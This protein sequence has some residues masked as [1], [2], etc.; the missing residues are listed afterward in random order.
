MISVIQIRLKIYLL[1]DIPADKVQAETAAFIDKGLVQS[2]QFAELHSKNRYKG[3]CFDS[4]YP[5]EADKIY[6]HD[7]IYTLTIRTIDTDLAR[8]FERQ[9]VNGYTNTMKALTSEI[10]IIPF[11]YIDILWPLVPVILKCENGYWKDTLS[12]EQYEE[13]LKINLLKKWNQFCGEKLAE[14]FEM[15][16]GIEFLNRSPLAVAYKGIRLLG[17]KPRLHIAEN[18]SAQKLAQLAIGTGV[19]EMNSR[20]CGFC[21]YRWL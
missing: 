20:G 13:R 18:E 3:Y 7:K 10:K 19:G 8:F 16:I 2:T 6:H 5:I 9:V 14:D 17:D 1:K 4:L 21:N 12:V 15:F 11:K